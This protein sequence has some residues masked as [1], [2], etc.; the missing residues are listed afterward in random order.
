MTRTC[1]LLLVLLLAIPA[2]RLFA[3]AVPSFLIESIAVEGGSRATDRIV[4]AESG[5]RPNRTYDEGELRAGK[6]RIQRLPFIVSTD[7]R[8]AKGTAPGKYVLIIRIRRMTPFFLDAETTAQLEQA[9]REVP[10]QPPYYRYD[11][12]TVRHDYNHVVAGAR[13][14]TGANGVLTASGERVS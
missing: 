2:S 13:L 14:F 9:R 5:L 6:G 7:F 3:D 4:V 1:R 8:L 10:L 11:Y 12:Y